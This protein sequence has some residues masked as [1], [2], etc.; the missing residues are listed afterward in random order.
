MTATPD[1]QEIVALID[2]AMAAGARRAAACAE[3]GLT[4]RTLQRWTGPEGAI[5]DDR[6]PFAERPEPASKLSDEE[7]CRIVATCNV[8]EFASLPPSQIVPQL[9]DRGIR[10]ASDSSFYRVLRERGQTHRRSRARPATRRKPPTS[11]EAK[12][13]CQVWSWD[14]TWLP[15]PIAGAFFY[16]Y[17]IVDIFSRKIVGWK[18]HD[19]ETADFAAQV[20]E[21]AV[22]AERCLTGPLVLHADNGSPM[23]GATMERLGV[24]ASFSRPR[25]SNDNP[26]SE[27]LFRT[28]KDTPNWPTRG[29]AT[30]D[31]AR[32]WVQGFATWYNIDHRHSALRFVTPD[33]RH[34]G[35]DRVLLDSR[36]Q[37]YKMARAARPERW[38]G[39]TR[40]WQPVG[41]VW[42]NPQRPDAERGGHGSADALT[43]EAGGGGPLAGPAKRAA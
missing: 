27:A 1:R 4:A 34:R 16:L 6:R 32:T 29:F 15:G 42:L 9:A 8:P 12:A 13:P 25:V 35:E 20:L 41:P 36:H 43:Q 33:Q 28:C 23:K 14:I 5:C 30:I 38:S 17:L 10:I 24:T 22:R 18:V 11:F 37:V 3:P 19:R 31:A 39:P 21:R 26:F 7:R 40:N 2:K